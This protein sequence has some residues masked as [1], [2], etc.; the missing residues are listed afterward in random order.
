MKLLIIGGDGM[1]GHQLF[2][3]LRSRHEI[4]VTLRLASQAY[5]QF[6]FFNADNAHFDV[7]ARNLPLLRNIIEAGRPDAVINAVGIV[8]QRSESAEV[9]RSIQI[10]SLFPH[11]LAE[12]ARTFGARTIHFSTD[13]V[14]SGRT[15]N[16]SESDIADAT[17]L[18]ARTKLLGEIIDTGCLTLRTSII[19]LELQRKLGLLEW[20]LAQRGTIRGFCK[21]IYSGFTTIEMA[22]VVDRVLS[23]PSMQGTYHVSSA[24]ISK[25]TLL[26]KFR[27]EL[28]LDLNILPDREFVCDRSLN[29]TLFQ[30][31]FSYQP[32]HW[33]AMITELC[34]QIRKVKQK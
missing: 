11:Q 20:F 22:R 33:D 4:A 27:D 19:G 23:F 15:G 29:S 2:N 26:T 32:P 16:Y 28:G 34:E 7:D 25:Y 12:I 31:T 6:P 21:A 8:K 1:L 13:C 24:P 10:N 3:S 17:D 30:K 14:F 5:S 18:Y 9:I